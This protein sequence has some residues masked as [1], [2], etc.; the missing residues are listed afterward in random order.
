MEKHVYYPLI[1]ILLCS[2]L[3]F[4]TQSNSNIVVYNNWNNPFVD[5]LGLYQYRDIGIL[6]SDDNGF[7]SIKSITPQDTCE[8]LQKKASAYHHFFMYKDSSSLWVYSGDVG[9]SEI[10]Q[11]ENCDLNFKHFFYD[12]QSNEIPFEVR[13]R[14]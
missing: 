13:Q 7:L 3:S 10:Q 12:F 4:C 9:L 11:R 6:V 2:L 1:V 5:D 8:L 14:L